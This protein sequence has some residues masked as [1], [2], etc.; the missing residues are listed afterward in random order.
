MTLIFLATYGVTGMVLILSLIKTAARPI[1]A[2]ER[3]D[4]M[5]MIIPSA[6]KNF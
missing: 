3:R 6:K 4:L 2:I 5:A 1:P